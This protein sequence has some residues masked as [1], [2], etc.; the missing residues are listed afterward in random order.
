MV[1]KLQLGNGDPLKYNL[2][3]SGSVRGVN[4]DVEIGSQYATRLNLT[5]TFFDSVSVALGWS[6]ASFQSSAW[7]PDLK[8]NCLLSCAGKCQFSGVDLDLFLGW[9][10]DDSITILSTIGT[11]VLG[12]SL[13]SRITAH[14]NIL[15]I[16]GLMP[17]GPYA[18]VK[19]DLCVMHLKSARFGW[20]WRY[21]S[22]F[23][24]CSLEW[25]KKRLNLGGTIQIGDGMTMAALFT[26]SEYKKGFTVGM[27]V[28][29]AADFRA[30][31]GT[32]GQLELMTQFQPN[33][34]V[35]V[36]LMSTTVKGGF[37]PVCFGWSL[38]FLLP[39]WTPLQAKAVKVR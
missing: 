2:G 16:S 6:T 22:T 3:S 7:T 26:F 9:K 38:D 28:R 11:P 23:G 34:W 5:R 1:S 13:G 37:E 15:Q 32:D 19:A 31:F 35:V 10:H 4:V 8:S 24:F 29:K 14:M 21:S 33:R 36:S 12:L 18:S 39:S 27:K 30:R 25:M 20:I 17:F